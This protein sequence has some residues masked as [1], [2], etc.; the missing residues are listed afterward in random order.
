MRYYRRYQT[1]GSCTVI[2]THCF[3]TLGKAADFA[4]AGDLEERHVCGK[5]VPPEFS[6]AALR[7]FASFRKP[8]GGGRERIVD[9]VR[10]LGER[11]PVLAFAAVALIVYG[12]PTLI[13]LTI[14]NNV[15]PWAGT[16]V[17]GDLIG[18]ACL[19][20]LFRMPATA[21]FLYL[22]L[23]AF[24]GWLYFS[25]AVPADGLAWIADSVPMLAVAGRMAY[26]RSTAGEVESPG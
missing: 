10:R 6:D 7:S 4:A 25:G 2:C 1:D 17:F 24:E 12:V 14:A 3:A 13:E 19:A 23:T 15:T 18:C 22:G 9:F 21:L 16:V 11:F 5:A 20:V 8:A 26:L